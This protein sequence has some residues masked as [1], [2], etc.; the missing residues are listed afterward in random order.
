[1]LARKPQLNRVHTVNVNTAD[2]PGFVQ[3][4]AGKSLKFIPVVKPQS[5]SCCR[6]QIQRL[7]RAL[8]LDIHFAG[9]DRRASRH[10]RTFLG[11]LWCP[12]LPPV[13]EAGIRTY[14]RLTSRELAQTWQRRM[15]NNEPLVRNLSVLDKKAIDWLRCN[16]WVRLIDTDNNLGTTLVESQWIQ[17]QVQIWLNKM[18]RHI[19]EAEASQKIIAGAQTSQ[20]VHSSQV[21]LKKSRKVFHLSTAVAHPHLPFASSQRSTSSQSP[22]GPLVIK[23]FFVSEQLEC[24]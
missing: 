23:E 9:C 6:D 1:M 13:P 19:T 17:D 18:T 4:F 5:F 7:A 16:R 12:Q 24:F 14:V 15:L 11:S 21:S 3:N 10:A 8:A 22:A 20:I 2:I